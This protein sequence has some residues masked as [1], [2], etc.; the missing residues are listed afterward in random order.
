MNV[1]IFGAGALGSNLAKALS[2]KGVPTVISNSR[3]PASLAGLVDQLGPAVR[4]GTVNEA[5]Q[6]DIVVLAV[7]WLD[8]AGALA[9]LPDWAG[10]VVID[11]TNPLAAIDP[12]SSD[13]TDPGNPFAAYG[14]KVVDTGGRPSS[15]L[16]CKLVPGAQL[17][18][19]FNHFAVELLPERVEGGE[20]VIFYSGDESASKAKVHELI[21]R[22]GMAP[23][24]L[25]SIAGG[26]RLAE[27]P[28]GPLSMAS[29]VRVRQS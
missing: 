3:G 20:R 24:D 28:S 9:G 25:G 16:V 8:L 22:L 21:E 12:N 2:I 26:G 14:F 10:R 11:A 1:G 19:A 23:V 15:E 17:V 5:V 29:F 18:K 27:S 6:C 7:Q 4:A 13:A